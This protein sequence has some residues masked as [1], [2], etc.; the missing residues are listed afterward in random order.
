[1]LI[2]KGKCLWLMYQTELSP[3]YKTWCRSHDKRT[4]SRSLCVS[5]YTG[6]LFH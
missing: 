3:S 1:M 5:L 6:G 4:H 2:V